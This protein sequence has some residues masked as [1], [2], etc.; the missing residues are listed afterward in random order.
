MDIPVSR[1]SHTCLT[2]HF[3]CSASVNICG[4]IPEPQAKVGLRGFRVYGLFI[5][6]RLCPCGCVRFGCA[7]TELYSRCGTR[8]RGI[9]CVAEA[10]SAV[11]A[12]YTGTYSR[13]LAYS[14]VESTAVTK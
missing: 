11:G 8:C 13:N 10:R 3:P 5:S 4:F 9:H 6:I 1:V 2:D 14:S 7:A 12:F